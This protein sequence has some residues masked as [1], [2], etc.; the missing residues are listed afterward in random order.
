MRE[1][2]FE[3]DKFILSKAYTT[4]TGAGPAPLLAD[5][6]GDTGG[7][8]CSTNTQIANLRSTGSTETSITADWADVSGANTYELRAWP[9]GQF[10]GNINSPA[11]TSFASGNASPVTISGLVKGTEYTLV[12]RAICS[13]GGTSQLSQINAATSGGAVADCSAAPTGLTQTGSTTTSATFTFNNTSSNTR[14]F[15]IRPYA[16]G[17]FTG[18][19]NVGALG[20]ASAP[21]GSTS[22]SIGNLQP[23]TSYDFVFRAI[24]TGNPASPTAVVSGSTDGTSVPQTAV[25]SPIED[26]FVQGSAGVNQNVL[27][28]QQ[29][30][31]T[32]Y[33]KF[34]VSAING[35][36]TSASLKLTVNDDS[37]NGN[38]QVLNA[39]NNNWSEST[40]NGSNA[41]GNGSAL[42]NLNQSFNKQTA[43]TFNLSNM[44]VNGNFLSLV[45]THTGGNDVSF[46][47]SEAPSGT[48]ELTVA[49]NS[50]RASN[51]V[52]KES[53][54]ATAFPNPANNQVFLSGL[55][56]N[57]SISIIDM[58]GR[59]VVENVLS[60]QKNMTLDITKLEVGMY[61]IKIRGLKQ[62]QTISFIKQ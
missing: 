14:S 38:I 55:E 34:D 21:A 23:G 5:C 43:Y 58:A 3:I 48:P 9:K 1:D 18:N 32:S 24:C 4:P 40:I 8:S 26:A 46:K 22:I 39:A 41:P 42:G 31:R 56:K 37:G 12:L 54:I 2:G 50:N 28:V 16:P 59:S 15:E 36:I 27:R 10:T 33:L 25:L 35:P 61:F 51:Q 44:T 62:K 60:D 47:S 19:I 52:D 20:Y 17:T 11:A 7:G 57:S 45:V 13:S 53:L 29:G 30:F 49:F 6:G